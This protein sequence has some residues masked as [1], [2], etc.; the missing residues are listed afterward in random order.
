[1][2]ADDKEEPRLPIPAHGHRDKAD[3]ERS[4]FDSI[5]SGGAGEAA[6]SGAERGLA[7]RLLCSV[8]TL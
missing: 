1:M 5:E 6:Q 4:S 3:D 2:R 7:R 8:F